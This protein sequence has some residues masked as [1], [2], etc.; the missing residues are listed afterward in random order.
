MDFGDLLEEIKKDAS[1][2][3]TLP[4]DTVTALR[5][6]INPYGRVIEG[7]G[8]LTC[9]SVVNWSEQYMKRFLMT[10]L[11]GFLYRQADEYELDDGEPPS[12]HDDYEKW[13]IAYDKA[14]AE[15]I[16]AREELVVH[17]AQLAKE[18]AEKEAAAAED[19]DKPSISEAPEE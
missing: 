4:E 7:G 15:G 10:A 12:P 13:K 16:T 8:K 14:V 3:D 6:H 1:I 18:K 17:S 19:A 5:K 11:I 9:M 2:I